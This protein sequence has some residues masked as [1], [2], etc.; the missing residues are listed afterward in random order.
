MSSRGFWR[1]ATVGLLGLAVAI[2]AAAVSHIGR[3]SSSHDVRLAG[4]P[5]D[6]R[7]AGRPTDGRLGDLTGRPVRYP[8]TAEA[9]ATA[10]IK[11][12]AGDDPA[13]L[14]ALTSDA[15]YFGIFDLDASPYDQWTFLRC[16]GA[17]GSSY[18]SFA[19]PDGDVLTLRISNLLLG[20]A[21]AAVDV[22]LD[23][24]VYPNDAVLYVKEFVTAWQ[25]GNTARMLTLSSPAVVNKVPST[26]PTSVTYLPL[27]CCGG[28]LAQVKV[29]IGNPTATFDVGTT[30]LGGPNA[31]LDY[32]VEF[33]LL[34]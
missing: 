10:V 22:F 32:S 5:T 19:N 15:V 33:G 20:Q 13:W 31:I 30:K 29:K 24:T 17:A 34:L 12:W 6:V 14:Q 8:S 2:A 11:A 1:A 27:D 28:G 26:A 9:Y 23:K 25:F 18:C 3:A 16:D 4:N 21:D 7:L